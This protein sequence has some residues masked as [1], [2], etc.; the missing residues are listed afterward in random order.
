M[1]IQQQHQFMRSTS[2]MQSTASVQSTLGMQPGPGMQLASSMQPAPIM[3]PDPSMQ[4]ASNMQSALGLTPL[5][6]DYSIPYTMSLPPETQMLLGNSLDPN[7]PLTSMMMAGSEALPSYCNYGSY[8]PDT[9]P[10]VTPS[11]DDLTATLAPGAVDLN[12]LDAYATSTLSQEHTQ[13]SD[14]PYGV[15]TKAPSSSLSRNSST[16]VTTTND[17]GTPGADKDWAAF[18][19]NDWE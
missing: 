1:M 13:I 9:K 6:E 19:D 15:P 11:Y 3:Q 7:D 4:A 12:P 14:N 18:I 17:G 10:Q 16:A 8:L 5:C 2:G